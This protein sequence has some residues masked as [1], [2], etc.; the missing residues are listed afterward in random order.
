MMMTNYLG[1]ISASRGRFD[2]KFRS[3]ARTDSREVTEFFMLMQDKAMDLEGTMQM[4]E[5]GRM[6]DPCKPWDEIERIAQSFS[7][8]KAER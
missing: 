7:K 4:I 2:A 3:G 6:I 1:K 8:R 5:I